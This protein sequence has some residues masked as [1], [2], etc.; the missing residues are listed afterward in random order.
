M[1]RVL[2]AVLT[3]LGCSGGF[4]LA[5]QPILQTRGGETTIAKQVSTDKSS[6]LLMQADDLVYD[7]RNNRVI[8]RGNVE[9]Y[10][11]EN[12]LLADQ[13][14]YDKTANTLT[15]LGNVRLKEADGS[16]V[17]ADRLTL[18]SNFR[19]GFIRSMRALTQDDSR[20]AASN[21][22]RKDGKTVFENGVVTGC[23]PCEAHPERPPLWR[24]KATRVIHDKEEQNIYYENAQ[25][26]LYGVPVAWFPY[27]YTPD[28][29]VQ[30]RSGF[31]A[32]S[33]GSSASTLGYFATVP[34]YWAISPEYD[35]TLSPTFTTKA[36]YLMQTE[37]R[38]RLWN[39]A[40]EVKLAG[41]YNDS[42]S[43]LLNDRNWR[44]SVETKGDFALNSIWHFGWNAIIESDDTFRRFYRIDD[45]YATQRVSQ[46]YLTGMGETN[47]FNLAFA[48]YGNLTGDVYMYET[49]TYQKTITATAYPTLD[50][51]YIHNK[52]VF[53]GELSVDVN[54][55]ALSV[56]DPSV[57]GSIASR[58]T[59]GT[60][61]HLVTQAQWRRTLTDDL[62]E[63]FTPF[64]LARG[65][66]YNTS[67]FVDIDGV[68]GPA[69]TFTRQM[70]GAGLDYRYPFVSHSENAS[71]VI[72][73]VAQIIARAGGSNKHV[74][75]EDSQSLV[76]DDT[77]LF[78][79]DKFSGYDRMETGTRTNL[80]V[81]YT[82]QAYNGVSVRA[83][84]GESIHLAGTNP[85]DPTTGLGTDRSDYVLGGYIDYKNRF[86]FLSQFRFNE[87]DFNLL[88]QSYVA[89]TKLGFFEGAVSY[90]AVA[91]QPQ[92]GFLAPRDEV[93]GFAAVR[94]NDEWTV[95]GD[96]RYDIDINHWV[97]N[98]AGVQYADECFI[99]S[100]TYQQTYIN[101]L[102]LVPDTSVL[103]RVGFKG[104]G[105]QT[106]PSAIGDLSPEAAAFR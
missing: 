92:L 36:G 57:P 95:F 17:N 99:L 51:N 42:T 101:Y 56:T 2:A 46:I 74:P 98:A 25:F 6:P 22:Y 52:P 7:N 44:G 34:Y 103:V 71:H 4:A 3:W 13:I 32:P 38:Q 100:V 8:A 84:G 66:L 27:F 5:Q 18:S 60:I 1:L 53:G 82:Y 40:Y 65:D 68:S 54:A 29:T 35:L 43:E 37:W 93:A 39:G 89:Q 9:I 19:D 20:V 102:D 91:A 88:R 30:R 62:G 41:A 77:L 48:R 49:G 86:R 67:R 59:R 83:L 14:I 21:A 55:L 105:Q 104:F 64:F 106:T 33:Y 79:V 73:P 70:V 63:R 23:K 85:Y 47:Y 75:N 97:R 16:V 28:P 76:F 26:E 72:E 69:D 24:V 61:D 15:A 80:G 78:D 11:N 90:V 31:L 58:T 45:V 96:M 10:Y 50:Y 94:L 12:V 81:Q 87:T